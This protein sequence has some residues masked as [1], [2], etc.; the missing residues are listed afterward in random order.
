[1]GATLENDVWTFN[2]EPITLIFLIRSE[3]TRLA[4]GGYVAT[5]LEEL[6]FTVERVERTSGELSPI[7]NAGDPTLCEWHLYTGAWSQ[8]QIDR[9]SESA[10]EQYYTNRVLPWP[11]WALYAPVP[12]LD[13]ASR[14]I[15]NNDFASIEERTEL[16]RTAL[17]L[18]EEYATRNWI[19]SRTTL[20]PFRNEVSVTTDL[21]GGVSGT[22]LWSKTIRFADEVGGSMN[23]CLLYTSRCV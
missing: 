11:L 21:A 4:I 5:Q 3:D 6:G 17:T 18:S 15:Y 2:G 12:E 16:I 23:I 14:K 7:W 13:E 9:G 22:P 8:T 1:M 10:F 19:T 20:V